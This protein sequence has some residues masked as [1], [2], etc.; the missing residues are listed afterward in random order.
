[1]GGF[2]PS[3]KSVYN[4]Q[5]DS[6]GNFSFTISIDSSLFKDYTL[7]VRVL[8]QTGYLRNNYDYL[9]ERLVEYGQ[10]SLQNINFAMYPQANLIIRLHR[11]QSDYFEFFSI[12]H[13]Y[14]SNSGYSEYLITGSQF[15]SDTIINTETSA[16]IYTKVKST[17]TLGLGSFTEQVD[18]IICTSN[19]NNVIDISY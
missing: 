10:T 14:K 13:N 5:A 1:M 17:K 19:S 2:A 3:P 6:E 11:V 7:G 18:S 16:D 4:G 12:D 9:E 15:A 8:V